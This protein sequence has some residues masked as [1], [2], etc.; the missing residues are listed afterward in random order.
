LANL[1]LRIFAV[2]KDLVQGDALAYFFLKAAGFNGIAF[3][4]FEL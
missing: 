2:N 4:D 1:G 3:R